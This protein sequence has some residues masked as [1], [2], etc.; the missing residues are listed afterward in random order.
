MIPAAIAAMFSDRWI[1]AT[2]LGWAVGLI[3]CLAGLVA[4]FYLNLPYGPT[5]VL[6]LGLFF[7]VAV[8]LRAARRPAV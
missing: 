5:L 4:S 8:V 7:V 3:A 6:F 1:R 2:I